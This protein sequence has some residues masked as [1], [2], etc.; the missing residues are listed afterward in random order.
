M[1]MMNFLKIFKKWRSLLFNSLLGL[2]FANRVRAFDLPMPLY[3]P[4]PIIPTELL[5]RLL[6]WIGGAFVLLVVAPILGLIWY[7]KRGGKKK[8]PAIIACI[9][10]LLFLLAIGALAFL[11][12]YE[13]A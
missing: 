11:I 9:L 8:W 7:R 12:F 13:M 4:E 6:P 5:S 10:V 3:G 1:N 2:M